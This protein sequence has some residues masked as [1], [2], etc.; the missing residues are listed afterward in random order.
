MGKNQLSFQ[1][2]KSTDSGLNWNLMYST[3]YDIT[4][5]DFDSMNNIY[6][7]TFEGCLRSTDGGTNWRYFFNSMN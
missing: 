6:L 2:F 7:I 5:F 4:D 1:L 3:N